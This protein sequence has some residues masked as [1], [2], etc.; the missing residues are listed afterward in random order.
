M[1][2]YPK[3]A[4]LA[5]L[6]PAAARCRPAPAPARPTCWN[7]WSWTSCSR[8]SPWTRS[9][10]SPTPTRPPWN[11]APASAR[12]WTPWWPWIRTRTPRIPPGPSATPERTLL[13]QA[14]RGFDQATIATIHGFCRRIL[15][16]GAFEG[17]TLLRQELA[18]GAKLFE[19]AFREL[20]R[21][22]FQDDSRPGRCSRKHAG[23]MVRVEALH[24]LL[25]E[26]NGERGQPAARAAGPGSGPGTLRSRL[27]PG[28][29]GLKRNCGP[30]RASTAAPGPPPS[31]AFPCSW[32]SWAAGRR[33]SGFLEDWDFA[34]LRDCCLQL[35]EGSGQRLGLWLEATGGGTLP[36]ENLVVAALLPA[37]QAKVAEIK[38]AEGL[39]DHDDSILQVL[40]ALQGPA[41]RS[42]VD[43]IRRSTGSP[44]STSSRTRTR[45]SGRSSRACS[46]ARTSGCTSSATPSRPSTASGAAICPPTTAPWKRSWAAAPLE[47]RD[48]YR[49]TPQVI[50]AYN[51]LF[52]GGATRG[53]RF[54]EDGTIYP[55]DR[56]VQLRQSAARGP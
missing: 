3:P 11:C 37:I 54:F 49:S 31:S 34:G 22:K 12:C 33:P 29:T 55:P 18:D 44:S 28:R 23:G 20:V 40:R 1:S 32:S 2:R 24:G 47:L 16:E 14:L 53:E 25:H 35:P 43:R 48:N 4:L 17:G 9:S 42:L 5:S 56:A 39:F 36:V 45:P 41:A 52:T 6:P 27:A 51:D 38:A 8:A 50:E 15:V 46:T 13:R 19:Q 30:A 10:W 21:V 26:A 7:G